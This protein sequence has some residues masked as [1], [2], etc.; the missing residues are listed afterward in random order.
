[1]AIEVIEETVAVTETLTATETTERLR[2]LLNKASEFDKHMGAYH[3][4]YVTTEDIVTEDKI[5]NTDRT[6]DPD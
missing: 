2:A 1:M 4:E 6:V 3:S 5:R